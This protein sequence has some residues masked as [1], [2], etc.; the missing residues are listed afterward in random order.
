[1]CRAKPGGER[2]DPFHQL[3]IASDERA[4]VCQI[5]DE[6]RSVR[7]AR[8]VVADAGEQLFEIVVVRLL[9]AL[10]IHDEALD[11]VLGQGF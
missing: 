7:A 8:S 10:V 1:M 2:V 11:H 5:D 3:G 4:L 9:Q 6:R